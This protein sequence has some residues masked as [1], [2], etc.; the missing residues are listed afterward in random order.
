[1]ANVEP[2]APVIDLDALLKPITEEHPSG[3][4]LQYSG[5]YDEIRL[6]RK[7]DDTMNQG[8]W[9]T[10]VKIADYRKVVELALP[11]LS[12]QS[13]DLQICVW[14]SEA[15]TKQNGFPGLRDS[16]KLICAIEEN[17]WDT[18]F[19]EI[20]EGDMEGRGNATEWLDNQV[21]IAVKTIPITSGVGFSYLDWD[22]S[23]RFD[24][25]EN[26]DELPYEERER[27]TALKLQGEQENR[28]TG[29]MWRAAKAST[30]RAFYEVLSFTLEEC[31]VQLNALDALNA[32]KF[33]RNQIPSVR[34]LKKALEDLKFQV[35]KFLEEKRL[36]EPDEATPEV[37]ETVNESGETVMVA[38][39]PGVATG[40]IQTRQDALRRLTDVAE[41]FRKNEPHSPISYLIQRAV[42]WG[43]MPLE[44]WLQ[45]VIKDEAIIFQLRQTL[46]FNTNAGDSTESH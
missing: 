27:L 36:A 18:M 31:W 19:P 24:V 41:Y 42:K 9:Q 25:P 12:T 7:A 13:K 1:M 10:D 34:N 3:E 21:S 5:L 17:F 28:K 6:A 37:E 22:E 8:A 16:L 35:G 20:D 40:A 29:D 11:A 32:E 45:D 23:T 15:L 4:S 26:L 33:D 2:I 46:G 39:G 14:L 43:N 44:S 30:N 38:R